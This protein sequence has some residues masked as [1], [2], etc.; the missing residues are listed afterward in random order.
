MIKGL[1]SAFTA[2]EA[3]WQYQDVLANNAANASTIGYKRE[4]A[5]QQSFSDV[6]LS[7]QSPVVSPL[8]ERIQQVV[9]Q[10]G[11]GTFVAE[12]STHF[13]PG[14]I[15]AT[16]QELDLALTDGFFVV[17]NG[18]G[19]LFY[20]RDG[21]LGRD[22]NG[23]LVTSHGY[24]VLNPEGNPIRVPGPPVSVDP[25]GLIKG[26]DGATAQIQVVDF[27]PRDLVRA[28]E[29]YFS[30]EVGGTPIVGGIR[31]G[32]LESSNTDIVEELT[33]LLAVQRTY[34]ANQTVFRLLD[35]NLEQAATIGTLF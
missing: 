16:G 32:Y 26:P 34:A 1:Y 10:I 29:A 5:V 19:Q 3:A 9:G 27:A 15:E 23:D 6:L 17:R 30:S 22:A 2:L 21:R 12:F 33:T 13:A 11:T 25:A 8:S 4:M 18:E 24:F 35:G 28:G 7:Q 31:Q 20:T 14:S